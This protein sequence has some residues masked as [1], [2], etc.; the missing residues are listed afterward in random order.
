MHVYIFDYTTL[1]V[2]RKRWTRITVC[3]VQRM[4]PMESVHCIYSRCNS[5]KEHNPL[6]S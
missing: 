1:A 3:K 5:D 6:Q 2:V 4:Q